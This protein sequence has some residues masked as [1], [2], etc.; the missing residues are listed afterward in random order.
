MWKIRRCLDRFCRRTRSYYHLSPIGPLRNRALLSLVIIFFFF[1]QLFVATSI[2]NNA[3][4]L[5]LWFSKTVG[6]GNVPTKRHIVRV[7]DVLW[8][9]LAAVEPQNR[10]DATR[11]RF[12]GRSV[13]S[14]SSRGILNL[15]PFPPPFESKRTNRK[16][17][18]RFDPRNPQQ[19]D[20]SQQFIRKK[21][22]ECNEKGHGKQLRSNRKI[23]RGRSVVTGVDRTVV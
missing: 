2:D 3:R 5:S 10:R 22:H 1:L 7:R 13:S 9:V 20:F 18:F 21:E 15:A 11:L 4:P 8:T 12:C 19:T 17:R 14:L 23:G 16:N 6:A